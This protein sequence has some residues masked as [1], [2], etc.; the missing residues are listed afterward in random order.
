[1]KN[2]F[3]NLVRSASGGCKRL[4]LYLIIYYQK[5]NEMFVENGI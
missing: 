4:I 1:M 2:L 5:I 3:Q